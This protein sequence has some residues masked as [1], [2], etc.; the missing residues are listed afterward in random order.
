[1]DKYIYT[2]T[3]SKNKTGAHSNQN[4]LASHAHTHIHSCTHTHTHVQLFVCICIHMY[5]R[6]CLHDCM[7]S[8]EDNW[9]KKRERECVC[10]VYYLSVHTHTHVD[11]KTLTRTH[12]R[13]RARIHT[14]IQNRNMTESLHLLHDWFKSNIFFEFLWHASFIRDTTH[15]HVFHQ[16][17]T[18]G[19]WGGYGQ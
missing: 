12:T 5:E 8:S 4:I 15:A 10:V 7:D 17:F 13:A 11:I 9:D 2:C 19:I 1:M 16:P 18:C 6:Y 14:Y 3:H